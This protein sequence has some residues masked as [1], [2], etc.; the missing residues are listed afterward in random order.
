MTPYRRPNTPQ[1]IA[2]NNLFTKERVIIERCFG[3]LKRRFPILNHVRVKLDKVPAITISCA[4][5]H[6]IAKYLRDPNHFEGDEGNQIDEFEDD[7]EEGNLRRLGQ[8]KRDDIKEVIYNL[9]L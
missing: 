8:R 3:Q 5:L 6:N 4:V 9:R 7:L 1:E 2:Y